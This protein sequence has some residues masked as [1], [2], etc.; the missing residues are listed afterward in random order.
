[1]AHAVVASYQSIKLGE[2]QEDR[3]VLRNNVLKKTVF[4]YSR[5]GEFSCDLCESTDCIHT[6]YAEI[7]RLV[8]GS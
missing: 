7:L 2:I 3:V 5:D 8:Q 4:V 6:R 1:M